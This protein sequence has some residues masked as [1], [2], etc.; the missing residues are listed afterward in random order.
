MAQ[1]LQKKQISNQIQLLQ[2]QLNKSQEQHNFT[3]VQE[4]QAAAEQLLNN[5]VEIHQ[6][7]ISSN[8]NPFVKGLLN[9]SEISLQN[10]KVCFAHL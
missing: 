9:R 6:T 8:I 2:Q 1:H 5:Q 7:L 4:Q 3:K 10:Q